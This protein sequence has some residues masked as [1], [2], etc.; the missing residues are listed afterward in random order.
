MLKKSQPLGSE[1]LDDGTMSELLDAFIK[2]L[3]HRAGKITDARQSGDFE[4]L[5]HFSHQLKGAAGVY[6]F[7]QIAQAANRV[8]Q[9]VEDGSDAGQLQSA[10]DELVK[11]C[12]HSG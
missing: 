9:C 10:V 3:S 7:P 1:T 8:Y 5:K 6:G 12:E 4:A 2:E 11:L